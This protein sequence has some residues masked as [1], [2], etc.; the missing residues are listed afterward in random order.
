M[1]N[2]DYTKLSQQNENDIIVLKPSRPISLEAFMR[3]K[4]QFS[5]LQ[6]KNRVIVLEGMDIEI[7]PTRPKLI[8]KLRYHA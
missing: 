8:R 6:I 3:I 7:I 4:Q 1:K 2:I 5:N